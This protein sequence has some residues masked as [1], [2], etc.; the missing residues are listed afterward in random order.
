[1]LR[2]DLTLSKLA[3]TKATTPAEIAK[4][5]AMR[6]AGFTLASIAEE[7]G[8]SVR[9]ISRYVRETPKGKATA[10]MVEKETE[11]LLS[12][13][14]DDKN[15]KRLISSQLIDD[16]THAEA[17]RTKA[18]EVMQEHLNPTDIEEAALCM[19]ALAAYSTVL[20]NT[21]DILHRHTK[22]YEESKEVVKEAFEFVVIDDTQARELASSKAN[23][24]ETLDFD[25]DIEDDNNAAIE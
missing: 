6:E 18:L 12:T 4:I 22:G 23:N 8:L 14:A 25:Y 24:V 20:K 3:E 1:M 13:L 17:I 5:K 19:R 2:K 7:S 10:A 16:L 15:I 9:Q 11:R 21:S